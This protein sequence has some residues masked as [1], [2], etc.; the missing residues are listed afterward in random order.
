MKKII[1]FILLIIFILSFCACKSGRAAKD[2][3]SANKS[4]T[5]SA[6]VITITTPY[7]DLQLK[8]S[9]AEN[10]SYKVTNNDPYTL[11]FKAKKDD[12]DLFSLVFDGTGDDLLGTIIGK[13]KNTVLYLNMFELDSK[14]EN[15][16][17]YT[18]YQMGINDILNRLQENTNFVYGEVVEYEDKSTFDI[19]T[20]LVTLKYPK[21]WE[22]K[23][24]IVVSDDGAKFSYKGV[25]LFDIYF[26]EIEDG[27]LIGTYNQTPIYVISYL[28]DSNKLNGEELK[29][30]SEMQYAI[31]EILNNLKNNKKFKI[32]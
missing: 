3:S 15:Y 26:K 16:Q 25:K 24:D 4:E 6:D 20:D 19:E 5:V 23:V 31:N 2:N 9:I 7:S 18:S 21:K 22:D 10:L 29:E 11:T 1:I 27:N 28:P 8:K 12:T 13:D 32:S 17:E 14:S 30:Y